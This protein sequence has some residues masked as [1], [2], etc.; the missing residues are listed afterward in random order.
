MLAWWFFGAL[1]MAGKRYAEFRF[2]GDARRSADYRKSFLSLPER[3]LILSMVTR[4]NFFASAWALLSRC[5]APILFSCSR[6]WSLP[7]VS[8]SIEP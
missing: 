4:A 6:S 8:I 2:I 5:I 3:S 7:S 1:L